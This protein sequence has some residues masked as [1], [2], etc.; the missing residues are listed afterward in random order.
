MLKLKKHKGFIL[1]VTMFTA[2]I[3]GTTIMG[4]IYSLSIDLRLANT[5]IQSLKSYYI[6]EAGIADAIERIRTKGPM[7]DK[8]W[9][10]YFPR[11]ARDQYTV[12]LSKNSSVIQSIGKT[13]A[14]GIS[15][16]IKADIKII[17][18]SSPYTVSINAWQEVTP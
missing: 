7:Q 17:G 1:V 13:A 12:S 3:V 5:H 4:M 9:K 11:S 6:A 15:R 8:K 10:S 2:L 14:S 16:A 18:N